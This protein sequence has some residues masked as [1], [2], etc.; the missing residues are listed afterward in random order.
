MPGHSAGPLDLPT[1]LLQ[2]QAEVPNP[3]ANALYTLSV[4]G[5]DLL[6]LLGDP[7]TETVGVLAAVSNE[8]SFISSLA[9]GGAHNFVVMDVP[10]L[11]KTPDVASGGAGAVAAAMDLTAEFNLNLTDALDALAASNH[12]N[13]GVIDADTVLDQITAD[14]GAYGF[15]N[16]TTPVW[17][18]NFDDPNSGTLVSTNPAIQ[19]SYLFWD[20]LHPTA[21]AHALIAAA[22]QTT[23]L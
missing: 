4:G 9:S 18:G 20:D 22:A 23:M 1:Q 14:P 16:V 15:A 6:Q 19:D 10:D 21:S 11:G 3:D 17:S 2:F 7:A 8:V 5:N 13:I 12:L